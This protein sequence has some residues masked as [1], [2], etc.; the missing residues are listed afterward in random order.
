MKRAT[1]IFGSLLICFPL[2]GSSLLPTNSSGVFAQ[3]VTAGTSDVPG[4]VKALA[5]EDSAKTLAS[6]ERPGKYGP[7]C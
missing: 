5:D 6:G 3:E 1:L 7:W 2:V 4:L